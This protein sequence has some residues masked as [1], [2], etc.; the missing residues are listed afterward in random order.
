VRTDAE[1][2]LEA[3]IAEFGIEKAVIALDN[4]GFKGSSI[5]YLLSPLHEE[6]VRRRNRAR[7]RGGTSKT[8]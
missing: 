8:L 6:A 2:V 1:R 4:Q 7:S 3:M 5:R